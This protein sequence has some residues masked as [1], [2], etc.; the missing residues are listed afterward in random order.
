MSKKNPF[1][2]RSCRYRLVTMVYY[3]VDPCFQESRLQNS[4]RQGAR[5][6]ASFTVIFSV[7]VKASWYCIKAAAPALLIKKNSSL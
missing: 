4:T 3:N 7:E 5:R 2:G 6:P 1:I